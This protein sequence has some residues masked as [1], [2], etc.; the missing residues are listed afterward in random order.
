MHFRRALRSITAYRK[1]RGQFVRVGIS[2]DKLYFE[3]QVL[4]LD[5]DVHHNIVNPRR[6]MC[7]IDPGLFPKDLHNKQIT[8]R[9]T[10]TEARAVAGG[11]H[12]I[13]ELPNA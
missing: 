5:P 4:L 12:L 3:Q 11:K 9:A 1:T 2:Q 10:R 6:S 13:Q 7:T 8:Y